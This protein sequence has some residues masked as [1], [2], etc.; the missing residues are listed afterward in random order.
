MSRNPI[1]CDWKW[2]DWVS[3]TQIEPSC[4]RIGLELSSVDQKVFVIVI[5]LLSDLG[6]FWFSNRYMDIV[7]PKLRFF[8]LVR[9]GCLRLTR[10]RNKGFGTQFKSGS[11][12]ISEFSCHQVREIVFNNHVSVPTL[13]ETLFF[14]I[15]HRVIF[16]KDLTPKHQV[17]ESKPLITKENYQLVSKLIEDRRN[18]TKTWVQW[19]KIFQPK[20]LS[21]LEKSQVDKWVS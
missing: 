15:I 6:F 11:G 3:E 21:F 19:T 2:S 20:I 9:D 16:L 12:E 7:S 10:K 8:G 1:F 5:W 4:D 17:L 14:K 13:S 18:R